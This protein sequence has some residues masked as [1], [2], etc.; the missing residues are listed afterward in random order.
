MIAVIYP[1]GKIKI[2]KQQMSKRCQLMKVKTS[3]VT[4]SLSWAAFF[5]LDNGSSIV[6]FWK[7]DTAFYSKIRLLC[8]SVSPG[9]G[10]QD[11]L[12]R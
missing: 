8:S 1:H 5:F 7:N 2:W 6:G 4:P 9:W 11:L 3:R 10:E 12:G